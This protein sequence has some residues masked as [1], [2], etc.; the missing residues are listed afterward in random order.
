[1]KNVF[2]N[3]WQQILAEEFDKP[4]YEQLRK[5][6]A[7]EFKIATI[8]PQLEDVMNAFNSVSYK[9]VKVVILGQDPYHGPGQAHGMSFSVRKGVPHPPSL[10]NIFLELHNDLGCSAPTDGSLMKW[11]EQ[12]VFLLN[13]VLTVRKGE[14]NSHKGIGWELFTDV[15]IEKLA[16]RQDPIIFVLWGRPAQTKESIIHKLGSHHAIIKAPHPS[17]LSAHR[18]FF[19]SKPFS[20]INDQLRQWEKQPINWCLN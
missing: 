20:K 1:M 10:R 8:Y 7:Q 5:K 16:Q 14:A 11:A 18:G 15:V 17:P 2:N 13:T 19:G 4:Y 6:V 9:D 12:G 3:D